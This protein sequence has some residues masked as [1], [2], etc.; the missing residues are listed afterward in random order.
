MK[1]SVILPCFNG[2]DT[3]AVQLEALANQQWSEPW[4]VIVSN[5]GS[6]DNSMAIVEQYRNRLPN[7]R[8]VDAYTPPEPRRGV[9]HSYKV[10]MQAATGDA[11]VFCEADDEVAPGWLAAMGEALKQYDFVAGALEYKKLNEPWLVRDCDKQIDTEL[12]TSWMVP[13]LPFSSGCKLGMKR[14]VYE[15]VGEF[16]ESCKTS[17]DTDYCWRVQR[18]G[19]KLHFVPNAVI[20][21]RLSH[22]FLERYRKSCKWGECEIILLKKH[23][24]PLVGLRKFKYCVRTFLGVLRQLP[25]VIW[26]SRS[27]KDF[28]ES[29][30]TLGWSIGMWQGSVKYLLLK[31]S[32]VN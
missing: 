4:E 11:F 24:K 18:A 7:L 17:W 5:N 26:H 9:T 8:I 32:D 16:D 10:G 30:W 15:T 25:R 20:H 12:Q 2:A 3:I 29:I 14:F 22:K 31:T 6:T 1:L 21:Y 27:K 19:I 28:A 13:G 23:G